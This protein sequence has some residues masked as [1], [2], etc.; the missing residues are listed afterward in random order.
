MPNAGD[1]PVSGANG[2]ATTSSVAILV[3]TGTVIPTA[4]VDVPRAAGTTISFSASVDIR[5]AIGIA[6]STSAG[7]S[8]RL[9]LDVTA[10]AGCLRRPSKLD[11]ITICASND[12]KCRTWH[13]TDDKVSCAA[14]ASCLSGGNYGAKPCSRLRHTHLTTVN[15][16]VC[17]G[18]STYDDELC[19][20]NNRR[21]M[22][23]QD[24]E[25][26][27]VTPF[28][29]NSD[30]TV[31]LMNVCESLPIA[32]EYLDHCMTR[33]VYPFGAANKFHPTVSECFDVT[34]V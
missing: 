15:R 27:Y 33:N 29:F 5:F 11:W 14:Y 26:V 8:G 24:P 18:T 20:F 1:V 34:L 17:A 28:R 21:K 3:A 12:W 23:C 16:D 31:M 13:R 25:M 22:R 6:H 30:L 32:I 10:R 4:G 19:P 2:T 9:T 7:S